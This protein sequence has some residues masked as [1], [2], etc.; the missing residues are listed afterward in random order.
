MS[1][2]GLTAAGEHREQRRGANER[3]QARL[4]AEHNDLQ[5]GTDGSAIV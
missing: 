1:L 5:S 4:Q 2:P 3:E